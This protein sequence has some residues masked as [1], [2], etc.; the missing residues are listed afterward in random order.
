MRASELQDRS[1]FVLKLVKKYWQVLILAVII[2]ISFGLM[3]FSAR[4][5]SLTNDEKIHIAAGYLHVWKGEYT[6]NVEHPPLL[7]DLAGL[8]AKIANPQLPQVSEPNQW[9]Y[10]DDFFYFS[11]NNVDKIVFWARLPFILLT[12]GLAYLVFLWSNVLFGQKAGLAAAA[13]TAFSPNIL[14]HGHLATTDIGLTFFF[15]L[16]LWLLRKYYFKPDWLTVIFLGLIL[17]LV[18]TA[19][20]SAIVI[21]PIV[22]MGFVFLG[23]RSS[24]KFAILAHFL[25]TLMIALIVIWVIYVFSMRSE[26]T[27]FQLNFWQWFNLPFKKFMLGL[28]SIFAHNTAGHLTYLNGQLSS[29]GWW[30]YFPLVLWYKMTLPEIIL[31]VLATFL[32]FWERKKLAFFDYFLIIFPPLLFLGVSMLGHLDIG[33][34][35]I[36]IFFPFAYIFISQLAQN[37]NLFVKSAVLVLVLGQAIIGISSFP[38]YIAYFNQIAGGIEG[39]RKH[40]ADSNLDWDQDTK[41]LKLYLQK[42]NINK[43]YPS[44]WDHSS[45]TY[46]GIK[47]EDLPKE[48]IRGVVVISD[49]WLKIKRPAFDTDWVIRFPPDDIVGTTLYVWRFDIKSVESRQ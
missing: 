33:I 45:L 44:L 9:K 7:N 49:Q 4:S 6:F 18:L 24:R 10:A 5:D 25:A 12:L 39:G 36:L 34:R 8:F 38:N 1:G 42:N 29:Q 14:A 13:L 23:F 30:Y 17:G 26:L 28:N 40:L 2:A 27:D 41:R 37:N 35:H 48:P 3:I 22:M 11:G 47:Y 32:A 15:V 31:L 43:I 20:F 21:F 46:Y 19:K 16:T